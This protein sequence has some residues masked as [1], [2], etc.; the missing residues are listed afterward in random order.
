MHAARGLDSPYLA[1]NDDM[2]LV[3]PVEPTDFF[4]NDGKVRLRGRWS[5]WNE[6]LEKG[7]SINDGGKLLGAEMLGYTPNLFFSSDHMNYPM[8]RPAMEELFEEFK[9]AFLTN[10]AYRFRNRKQFWPISAHD[11]LLLNSNWAR[12]AKP[13]N[14][15][16][17]SVRY[18]QTASP[19]ALQARLKQLADGTMRFA[20]INY[21]EVI[22]DK[23][24]HAMHYLSTAT[25]P[26]APFEEPPRETYASRLRKR[27]FARL[28]STLLQSA[29]DMF[30]NSDGGRDEKAGATLARQG[31]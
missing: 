15:A 10:A 21:L 23:V 1:F 29:R 18:C 31:R 6:Q 14:S 25:G 28:G 8:L 9:P 22:V 13:R 30:A 26:A 7:N 24:P 17:F 2:M 5:N 20:C 27:P 11:H 19:E 4:S 3:G 16:H 12:V